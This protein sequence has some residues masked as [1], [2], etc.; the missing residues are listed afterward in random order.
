MR[1][2]RLTTHR[3]LVLAVGT[4]YVLA[5]FLPSARVQVLGTTFTVNGVIATR[6]A[7]SPIWPA[8]TETSG[9]WWVLTLI[10]ASALTNVVLIL[11]LVHAWRWTSPTRIAAMTSGEPRPFR[12]TIRALGAS[13]VVNLY[14][15]V[16]WLADFEPG[17]W[18]REGYFLWLA[19]FIVLAVV[20]A[21]VRRGATAAVGV[22][23]HA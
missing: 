3:Y 15:P 4:A 21:R 8:S 17:D 9:P 11:A 13:A 22:Q 12:W 7:L 10:V 20:L 14:W 2:R 23:L 5:W 19:S 1:I 18:L 16:A 6:E